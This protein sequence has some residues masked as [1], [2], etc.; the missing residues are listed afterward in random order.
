MV[1]PQRAT[2]F[3]LHW[4]WHVHHAQLCPDLHCPAPALITFQF[5]THNVFSC[6]LFCCTLH[7]SDVTAQQSSH[8]ALHRPVS[9]KGHPTC[10]D[11]LCCAV[12]GF[13]PRHLASYLSSC[14]EDVVLL[15]EVWVDADAQQLISAARSAGLGHATHFRCAICLHQLQYCGCS[16]LNKTCDNRCVH[17]HQVCTLERNPPATG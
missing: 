16:S 13:A 14:Q 1:Q 7:L 17:N 12:L 9:M 2:V 6:Q 5:C 8:Q 15:Q 11:V 4:P 10:N 3:H